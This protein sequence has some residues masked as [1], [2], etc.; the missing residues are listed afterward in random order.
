[1]IQAALHNPVLFGG[2]R[3]DR[4]RCTQMEQ[5]PDEKQ[6]L[7]AIITACE[8]EERALFLTVIFTGL[9]ASELR[10]LAWSNIEFARKTVK[11]SQRAD[12][13]NQ[14]GLPKS[15]AGFRTIPLPDRALNALREWKLASPVSK[16]DLVFPSKKRTPQCYSSLMSR[17]VHPVQVRAG[18]STT[19]KGKN[20]RTVQKAK[21]APTRC[22]IGVD[23]P[24]H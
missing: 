8:C 24:K 3:E 11:V 19:S 23:R 12:S 21:Y 18:V 16:M 1:M 5:A 13:W 10:G 2:Q 6:E 4:Q 17:K 20:G 7:L 9:R 15:Q 22:R 14:V